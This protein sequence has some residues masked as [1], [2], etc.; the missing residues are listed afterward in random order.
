MPLDA[1]ASFARRCLPI[2]LALV[3]GA[4]GASR[5][6]ELTDLALESL[7][8]TEVVS[9]ARFAHQVT[10]AASAVSVLT[11]EEIRIYG[12]RTFGEVLDHMRGLHV[13]HSL[14]YV[15]LG[16]RGIGGPRSLAGRVLLLIDGIPALD[17]LYDQLYLGHD[18]PLDVALIDR[19]EYAPGS[20][21]AMY[22]NNAFLGVINVVTKRGRDIDG[23]QASAALGDWGERSARVSAGQR[24]PNGAEWLLSAT[25]HQNSGLPSAE[26]GDLFDDT[27]AHDQRLFFKG[28]WDGFSVEALSAQR[29]VRIDNR[30]AWAF[31]YLD[32]NELVS[33]GHDGRPAEGWRS[34]LRLQ[35]GRYGYRVH[36]DDTEL[37]QFHE[38]DDGVWW[39]LDSQFGY[40]GLAGH[41]IVLGARVRRD[42]VLRFVSRNYDATTSRDDDHRKS[43]GLSVEDE[44]T[45]APEWRVTG[46]LRVDRRSFSPWTWSPRAA[47]V[48]EPTPAWAIKLS[49]GRAT[50]FAST[51]ERDFG[52]APDQPDEQVTTRELV[53][54]YQRDSLRL[55]GSLYQFRM[56]HLVDPP[57]NA[58]AE[59]ARR[60]DGRGAEFE[61]EWQ[62]HG[63]RLRGSQAWQHA[64]AD[65]G[66]PLTYSPRSVS[67]LQ[68]SAPLAGEGL[69]LSLTAR[70]T[71]AFTDSKAN[72]VPA[73]TL[74]DLTLVSQKAVDG[75]DL[76]IGWRN[77]LREREQS[78][79]PYLGGPPTG[80]RQRSAWIELTGTFR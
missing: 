58:D 37:G 17:N 74:V 23:V 29:K 77:L 48:W 32:R 54:E 34:S 41:R 55:L 39:A 43:V 33:L 28:S 69:R 49:R 56:G 52:N 61:A 24:L 76:R 22:G 62:W 75:L 11:A 26:V 25:V 3:L 6:D 59:P 40:D 79:D 70:R 31:D 63:W 9:A 13:S 36:D 72:R 47:L 57:L 60:I 7:L 80:K 67:K 4:T 21:T 15:F 51:A 27:I 18:G 68:A 44:L 71:G 20:G 10:D 2:A 53:A 14:D 38:A 66:A 12:L 19:I 35:A 65:A 1:V 8:E 73:R 45:L 64:E 16:A 78:L 30:P 46:G 42:P 50:R 5:A